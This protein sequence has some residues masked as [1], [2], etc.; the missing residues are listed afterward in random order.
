MHSLPLA[1]QRLIPRTF[2]SCRSVVYSCA[3]SIIPITQI[4]AL[5]GILM[6]AVLSGIVLMAL[7][8]TAYFCSCDQC[9]LKDCK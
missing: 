2:K 6:H 8:A 5:G 7:H 4:L 1:V 3:L 9:M